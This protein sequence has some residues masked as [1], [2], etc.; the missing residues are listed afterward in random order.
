MVHVL[1][2]QAEAERRLA[3]AKRGVPPASGG[4]A[5]R[6]RAAY[7]L[8]E[9]IDQKTQ[10]ASRAFSNM[11]NASRTGLLCFMFFEKR[12]LSSILLKRKNLRRPVALFL[13]SVKPFLVSLASFVLCFLNKGNCRASF[14]KGKEQRRPVALFLK[15]QNWQPL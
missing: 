10:E 3:S 5:K 13:K 7:D 6:Q 2:V 12:K 11:Q 15:V 4:L 14:L 8:D 9:V 1:D